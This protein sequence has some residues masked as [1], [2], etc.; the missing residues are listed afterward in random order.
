MGLDPDGLIAWTSGTALV[1]FDVMFPD[2]AVM[3]AHALLTLGVPIVVNEALELCAS[4]TGPKHG[5]QRLRLAVASYSLRW[6]LT[7]SCCH[8]SAVRLAARRTPLP[9]T[10]PGASHRPYGHSDSQG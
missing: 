3:I 5:H 7:I 10:E 6:S 2:D 1:A 8:L 4:L 9:A